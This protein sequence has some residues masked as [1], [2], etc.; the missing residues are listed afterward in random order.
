MTENPSLDRLVELM[1]KWQY[2]PARRFENI[3]VH[4]PATTKQMR[5][6][7]DLTQSNTEAVAE[8]AEMLQL[9]WRIGPDQWTKADAMFLIGALCQSTRKG[10]RR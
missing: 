5:Y 1:C 10:P 7:S 2:T 6:I 3:A 8:I 4:E 9:A